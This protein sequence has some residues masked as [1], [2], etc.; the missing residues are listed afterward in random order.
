MRENDVRDEVKV[1]KRIGSLGNVKEN[2]EDRK[3]EEVELS[4]A[5]KEVLNEK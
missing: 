2:A 1:E 4:K 5:C 3:E